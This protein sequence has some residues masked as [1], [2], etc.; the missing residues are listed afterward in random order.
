MSY[1]IWLKCPNKPFVRFCLFPKICFLINNFGNRN[2]RKPIKGFKNPDYSWVSKK[3][4]AKN[5]V[6][7]LGAQVPV[8]SANM[9]KP[10]PIV[11]SP[12]KKPKPKTFHFFKSLNYKTFRIFR[13]FQLPSSTGRQVMIGQ[14]H[15]HY[16]RFVV[17]TGPLTTGCTSFIAEI[18]ANITRQPVELESCS[19]PQKMRKVFWLALRNIGKFWASGILWLTS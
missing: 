15:W 14:S 6:R 7:W 17:F 13:G 16:G 3:T 4:W 10:T 1:G 5:L 19:Y 12:T 18:C 11:T 2:A 8:T 9:H